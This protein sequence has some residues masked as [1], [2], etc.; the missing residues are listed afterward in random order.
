[1]ESKILSDYL[2]DALVSNSTDFENKSKKFIDE[3]KSYQHK[4]ERKKISLENSTVLQVEKIAKKEQYVYDISMRHPKHHYFFAN[5]ILVHNSS[6][7]SAWPVI[8]DEVM[9]GE[10]EWNKEVAAEVYDTISKEVSNTFPGFLNETF[11]VPFEFSEGVIESSREIVAESALFIK[12]KRYA[13]MVY[14]NEGVREDVDGKP[15][16]VK[17]MGLDLRRADTPKFVQEFLLDILTKVLTG[18]EYDELIEDIRQFKETYEKMDPWTKGTP[19]GVNRLTHYKEV[20]EKYLALKIAGKRPSKPTIPGHVQASLNWNYLRELH[21]DYEISPILDGSKVIVCK[22]KPSM[23]NGEMKSIAYPVDETRL[24]EWFKEIDFDTDLMM[25]TVV[26][27]KL[28]NLLGVLGWDL[29]LTT[30][31]AK[32]FDSLF[33]F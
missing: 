6:Y 14:D 24:P 16:K 33:G 21:K 1:M 10:I 5:D 30:A 13:A 17:A 27:Q 19:K 7:F 22:V 8:K 11:G 25:K 29:S 3:L 4:V 26:H 20:Q 12:K 28:E 32:H 18:H 23:E 2:F 15:G 9:S 31:S